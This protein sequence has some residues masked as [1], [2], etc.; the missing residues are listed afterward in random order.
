MD[1]SE[2]F[3]EASAFRV[4]FGSFVVG[5][6]GAVA[7]GPLLVR[8]IERTPRFGGWTGPVMIVGHAGLELVLVIGLIYGLGS[9]L[10]RP[11]V[12]SAIALVGGIVLAVFSG[13]M[14][15]GLKDLKLEPT[16][17]QA[18][19]A[20]SGFRLLGEGVLTTAANP[21]WSLWWATVGLGYMTLSAPLGAVGIAA[22]YLGHIASDFAWYTF[23]SGALAA[24]RGWFTDRAYRVLVGFCAST[25]GLFALFFIVSA[26]SKTR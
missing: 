9:F 7:P 10:E 8:V 6:S 23:I 1:F 19:M 22:F 17:S 25:L 11:A 16:G 2:F 12:S 4:A 14:F 3:F 21:Y 13:S 15:L 20:A 24:G 18:P 5:L 26:V